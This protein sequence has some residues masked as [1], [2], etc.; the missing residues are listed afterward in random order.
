M[1]GYRELIRNYGLGRNFT[2]CKV[3]YK[4]KANTETDSNELL[5]ISV[6]FRAFSAKT[7]PTSSKILRKPKKAEKQISKNA[8]KSLIFASSCVLSRNTMGLS[9][10]TGR[11]WSLFCTKSNKNRNYD[12]FIR[13][14]FFFEYVWRKIHSFVAI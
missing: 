9:K 5:K 4:I 1:I 10:C 6:I 3:K 8:T 12:N 7:Q 2:K 13:Y 11:E 14:Y